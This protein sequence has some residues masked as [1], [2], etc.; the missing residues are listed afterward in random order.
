[1]SSLA[2]YGVGTN[3]GKIVM[4]GGFTAV[5]GL[6]RNCVA[7]LNGD[8]SLDARFSPGDGANGPIYAVALQDDGKVV[9]GGEFTTFDRVPRNR[10]ARLNENGSLDLGFDPGAGANGPVYALAVGKPAALQV[11]ATNTGSG[12]AEYSTNINAGATSGIIEITYDFGIDPDMLRVYYENRLI[13][14]T[15]LT[16]YFIL[17]TNAD[18]TIT[19]NSA[20]VT[21]TF[22]YGPGTATNVTI[23]I[24]EGSVDPGAVWSYSAIIRP[25]LTTGILVGGDFSLFDNFEVNRIARLNPNGSLIRSYA[26]GTG[27]DGSV[28]AIVLQ[29]DGKVLL[30][31]A[32][33]QLN[34]LPRKGIGRLNADGSVDKNFHI[35][36]GT[37]GTV[38]SIAIQPDDRILIGGAFTAVNLTRRVCVARL[39]PE[40]PVD[41]SFMDT[42]YNQFAGLPNP[43]GFAPNGL[44]ASIALSSNGNVV[45]GGR[46]T[47]VGGGRTR[48][49][50]KPRYNYARLVGGATPGPGNL[51]FVARDFGVD[52]NGGAMAVPVSRTNGRLGAAALAA[53]TFDG[54]AL[55]K[56]DYASTNVIL[57]WPS[58][59]PMVSN[60]DA[61]NK[62]FS[63]RILDDNLIEG[64]ETFDLELLFPVG[65]LVL[66]G[67]RIPAGAALGSPAEAGATIV[68]NDFLTGSLSFSASSYAVNEDAGIVTIN[69][70]RTGSSSGAISVRYT[71]LDGTATNLVDYVGTS[72]SLSFSSGQTNKSFTLSMRDD[73]IVEPDETVTLRLSNPSGGATL[74]T[75][76]TA[77]LTIVDNDFAPGRVSFAT[78]NY[79][80][81][82][83]RTDAVISVQRRG[84]SVGVLSIDYSTGDDSATVPF[85]YNETAGTLTW[86]NGDTSLRTFIVAIN[87]DGLV[88]G[89]EKFNVI[90]SNPSTDGALATNQTTAKVTIADD[91]FYGKISLNAAAYL[92]DENG[93]N[94]VIKVIRREGSAG[95]DS[96]HE[97]VSVQYATRTTTNTTAV[98][99]T[100]YLDIS[101]TLSLGW[102]N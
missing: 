87:N 26:T 60:G 36:I 31:G 25:A 46:F 102:A 86:D 42:A 49:D 6:Q 91:D 45:A 58:V 83:S 40:G 1:M 4:A 59:G 29:R 94:V 73:A 84:G 61:A 30:G 82:E 96:V 79:V 62:L 57:L 2:I 3:N 53:L 77:V 88:E 24:N 12:P 76:A 72:G 11:G 56:L 52:E 71:T 48:V 20:P 38:F 85:D 98:P 80:V 37:D 51:Q 19:S 93:T 65:G 10:I 13:F 8:G 99:G 69:V 95:T 90:L 39:F 68:E 97:P 92:A 50:I 16:N 28:Q 75:N 63:V 5:N 67:E 101:G 70:Q 81:S 7:R 22:P 34:S 23:V 33:N 54:V 35:G 9:I 32:F 17:M 44:V 27:A 47:R 66:G 64:D 15:G 21:V 78:T 41:T 100:D 18:G 43:D 55:D 14:D 89:D 74:G